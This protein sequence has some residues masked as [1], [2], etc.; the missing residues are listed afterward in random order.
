[1]EIDHIKKSARSKILA[2]WKTAFTDIAFHL[3]LL[4]RHVKNSCNIRKD[5]FSVSSLLF[6]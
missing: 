4:T 1:M 6:H 3:P 5:F 2:E